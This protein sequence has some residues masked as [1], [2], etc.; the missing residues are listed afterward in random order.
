MRSVIVAIPGLPRSPM[1]AKPSEVV[2]NG[3]KRGMGCPKPLAADTSGTAF[4]RLRDKRVQHKLEPLK[5]SRNARLMFPSFSRCLLS[6]ASFV[7]FRQA[8]NC[9]MVMAAAGVLCA[10]GGIGGGGRLCISVQTYPEKIT[11]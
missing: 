1:F 4:R 7:T 11:P 8:A 6:L 5:A 2:F 9:C 10:A 3:P